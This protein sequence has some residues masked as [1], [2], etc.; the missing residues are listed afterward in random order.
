MFYQG[1][2]TRENNGIHEAVYQAIF[3][4]VENLQNTQDNKTTRVFIIF[5]V[6]Q[7]LENIK[8]AW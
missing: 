2:Q 3:I 7:I 5:R 1:F 4:V 6:S 8:N